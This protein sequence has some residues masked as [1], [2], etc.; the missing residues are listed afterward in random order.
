MDLDKLTKLAEYHHQLA[1]T[2]EDGSVAAMHREAARMLD[3][4]IA[5]KLA[6]RAPL[7]QHGV[8]RGGPTASRRSARDPDAIKFFVAPTAPGIGRRAGRSYSCS[9]L[10]T[11]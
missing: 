9:Y 8:S 3:E 1:E 5:A 10:S 2:S 11:G 4:I 7:D 6:E